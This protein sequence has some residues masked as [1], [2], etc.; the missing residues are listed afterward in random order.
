MANGPVDPSLRE[1]ADVAA[2]LGADLRRGLTPGEAAQRLALHGP[3]EVEQEPPVPLW[4]RL[5]DQMRNPLVY[6]LLGAVAVSM[7]AW[8]LEGAEGWPVDAVVIL[9]IVLL[10]AVLGYVQEAR[11]E[12]AVAALRDLTAAS[13]TVLRDGETVRIP[14]SAVV[15]GDVLV[16]AEGDKVAAD[17]RLPQAAA[18]RVAEASLTGESAP[19]LKGVRTLDA[20]APLGDRSCMVFAGTAV[21]QGAGRAVVTATGMSTEMGR[22]ARLLEQTPQEP[23][24]L[25]VEIARVGRSLGIAVLV[26]AAVVVATILLTAGVRTASEAVSVLLLGVSLAVAAVPEGLPAILTVVLALGVQRLAR[27]RAIVTRL[28]SVET[29]GS[30]SVICSDKTGTL[31]R[32]EMTIV[33][34][35][36]ASGEVEVTGTGYRPEGQVMADG[37]RLDS[38][39]FPR[40]DLAEEVRA[41]VVGGCLANDAALRQDADGAWTVQ[42]DP[43]EAAFLVAERKIGG[44]ADARRDRFRRVGLVPFTSERKVM[45]TLEADAARAGEVSV[46]AKGAP[47]VLLGRCTHRQ[48]GSAAVPLDDDARARVLADVDRL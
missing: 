38:P 21:A 17:A 15:P 25:E 23:T 29:L 3:N 13:A 4:R 36:T 44:S 26:I 9:V 16:L 27:H 22:I 19:V 32:N 24:P 8:L 45:S 40:P 18:L 14:A 35:V 42:G 33:R 31:T 6:L 12:R 5:L 20:A 39:A 2:D 48:V 30:A 41:V 46:V 37:V 1:V 11:A 28:S 34:V 10:N 43:G 7:V 47:D